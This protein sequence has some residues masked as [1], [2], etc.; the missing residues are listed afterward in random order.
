MRDH[1]RSQ[2]W[3]RFH[4]E[5]AAPL[6]ENNSKNRNHNG[7]KGERKK[8]HT[9]VSTLKSTVNKICGKKEEEIKKLFNE[10]IPKYI[11]TPISPLR[12]PSPVDTEFE[13]LVATKLT[14]DKEDRLFSAPRKRVATFPM[15]L[16]EKN[17]LMVECEKEKVVS[18][19]TEDEP[20]EK[21]IGTKEG[22]AME[23]VG[24]EEIAEGKGTIED[25]AK[26][27]VEIEELD[28]GK[29]DRT[30]IN[31]TTSEKEDLPAEKNRGTDEEGAMEIAEIGELGKGGSAEINHMTT[32]IE[33][34][35]GVLQK[36]EEDIRL[37]E[38][39][40][41]RITPRYLLAKVTVTDRK[42]GRVYDHR[43]YLVPEEKDMYW[44]ARLH[45]IVWQRCELPDGT[46]YSITSHWVP[47]I[48][49][50]RRNSIG[51]PVEEKKV[52]FTA[53]Q[54]ETGLENTTETAEKAID[55]DIIACR[56]Y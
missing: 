1:E 55:C 38:I 56:F 2:H 41:T 36:L 46:I 48:P 43:H 14:S 16:A 17:D 18:T 25:E 40:G 29:S 8:K 27:I 7:K 9:S 44:H 45:L 26:N 23:V 13:E 3:Y 37:V 28:E 19:E 4:V 21:G 15:P 22:D 50:K 42:Y 31:Y 11:A 6:K 30:E 32:T 35:E 12:E 24:I 54:T 5:Q 20:N 53:T 49:I 52:S 10:G 34:L 47:E 39:D 51:T 33:I